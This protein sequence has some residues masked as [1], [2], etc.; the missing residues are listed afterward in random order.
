MDK[1]YNKPGEEECVQDY[2]G[3]ARRNETS[4]K[5]WTQMWKK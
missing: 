1:A 2:S 4:M 5:T 3:K